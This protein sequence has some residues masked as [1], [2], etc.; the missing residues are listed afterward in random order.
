M[1]GFDIPKRLKRLVLRRDGDRCQVGLEGCAGTTSAVDRRAGKTLADSDVLTTPCNLFAS[2]W[3]CHWQKDASKGALRDEMI[4]RGLI[5]ARGSND[6]ETVAKVL[7]TPFVDV[8]GAVWLLDDEGGK[9]VV[10]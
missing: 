6:T 3:S 5:V 4:A 2:C 9:G 7:E 1:P 8:S 10:Q